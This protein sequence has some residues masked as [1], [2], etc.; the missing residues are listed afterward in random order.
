MVKQLNPNHTRL[1]YLRYVLHVPEEL[2]KNYLNVMDGYSEEWWNSRNPAKIA[3]YQMRENTL[4][5]PFV[6]FQNALE[7][8]LKRTVAPSEISILNQALRAEVEIATATTV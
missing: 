1:N 3:K 6:V 2:E 5:V 7:A 8:V 4:L